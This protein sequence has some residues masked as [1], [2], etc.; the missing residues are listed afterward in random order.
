MSNTIKRPRIC[1]PLIANTKDALMDELDK[2]LSMRPDL[3]EWRADY[4]LAL[5]D[6]DGL[7]STLSDV[8]D[9]LPVPMIFTIRCMAEGGHC[10]L[11][12]LTR[13]ALV[14]QVVSTGKVQM[15]DIELN[16]SVNQD[17]DFD[18]REMVYKFREVIDMA[19]TNNT[20]VILSNHDF[21]GTP[22]FGEIVA[23][24]KRAQKWN[25]DYCK[26]AYF[27]KDSEDMMALLSATQ[28]GSG[29]LGQKMIAVSMGEA[30]KLSRVICGEFG[31]EI[32]YA[33]GVQESAPG[34]MTVIELMDAWASALIDDSV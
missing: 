26:L 30:G 3:I 32:T 21:D 17:N 5:N 15:V 11:D 19:H 22:E 31:S 27:A 24:I 10:D 29:I 23:N 13:L 34:Q 6:F 1:I 14:Q 9:D 12:D 28:Y 16:C 8:F 2:V 18:D 7:L 33:R 25:A 20:E 4:F